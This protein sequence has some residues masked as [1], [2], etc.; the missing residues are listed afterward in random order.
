MQTCKIRQKYRTHVQISRNFLYALPVVAPS[1]SVENA[2]RYVF[3]V[4]WMTPCL[5]IVKVALQI[6]IKYST[7]DSLLANQIPAIGRG[8]DRLPN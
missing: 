2:I 8:H 5:H 7:V 1:L 4:L 3:P 6:C